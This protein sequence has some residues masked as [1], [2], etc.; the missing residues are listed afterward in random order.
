MLA[1]IFLLQMEATL[2]A[3]DNET[4]H[5]TKFVPFDPTAP[6]NFKEPHRIALRRRSMSQ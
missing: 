1:E 4:R 5:D 6:C 3:N 2:R